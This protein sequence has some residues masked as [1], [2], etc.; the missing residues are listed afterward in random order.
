VSKL[1]EPFGFQRVF[2]KAAQPAKSTACVGD[3]AFVIGQYQK[4]ILV[5]RVPW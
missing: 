3:S 4:L 5:L 1:A 2:I